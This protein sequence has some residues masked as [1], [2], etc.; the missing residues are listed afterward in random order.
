M[1]VNDGDLLGDT[2]LIHSLL[3]EVVAPGYKEQPIRFFDERCLILEDHGRNH[4]DH[5]GVRVQKVDDIT[6]HIQVNSI[7]V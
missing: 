1:E 7:I 3:A 4:I 5:L 6:G 2:Q